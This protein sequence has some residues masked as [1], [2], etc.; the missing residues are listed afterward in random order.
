MVAFRG[1][2][3]R[4]HE[5][6]EAAHEAGHCL[7]FGILLGLGNGRSLLV[8]ARLGR[9]YQS[10]GQTL[11]RQEGWWA[12]RSGWRL[13]AP[14]VGRRLRRDASVL[15]QPEMHRFRLAGVAQRTNLTP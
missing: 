6:R 13:L 4:A 9:L 1:S 8:V 14:A 5:C 10:P 12:A 15:L 3:R 2:A 7:C 11:R